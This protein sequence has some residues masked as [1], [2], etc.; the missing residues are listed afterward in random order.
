MKI[1]KSFGEKVFDVSNVSF[2]ILI[3]VAAMLPILYVIAGSFSSSNALIHNRVILWP[4]EATLD[5][6]KL[7]ANNST[8]WKAGW[9]T[10]QIVVIGTTVNMVLTMI[11]AYPL[12]KMDL[13]GRKFFM[14]LIIFTMIFSAP[15]IPS[16]LLVKNLFLLNSIWALILPG[17]ISAFNMILCM[18]F[19][20]TVPDDLFD[21]ARVDGMSEYGMVW[22]IV[23]PLSMPIVMTLLLFYAVGHWNNYFGPLLFINDRNKQTLQ[24]YLYSLIANGDSDSTAGAAAEGGIKLSPVAI[25]MATIVLATVPVVL[26]YPFLQKHFVKGALLG[27]VKE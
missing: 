8:F 19:F 10:V 14:L 13:K 12:S 23:V 11:T 5:N 3:T 20:R 21:A 24:M 2:L 22:R 26:I 6:F 25:Q 4:V 9:M 18:T 27:S 17:A 1:R 16:Y 7:V 15:I